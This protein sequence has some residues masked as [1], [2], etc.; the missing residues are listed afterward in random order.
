MK[1]KIFLYPWD[2]MDEG[3]RPLARRLAAL[4]VES[5]SLAVVYH[6]GKLLLP[7]NPRRRVLLHQD[8]RSYF[9]FDA[10]CYGRLRPIPGELLEGRVTSF[11][12][13]TL[14]AFH[15]ENIGVCAWVVVLHS[16]R[17]ARQNP[18]CAQQ[19]AWGEPSAHSLCPSHGEVFRYALSLLEDIARA[20]VDE[21]HLESVE[22]AGFLHGAHHEMQA[23]ANTSELDR[24]MGL[25][26]C[27]ACMERAKQ[28]G[29]DA[30]ALREAVRKRAEQFFGFEP[31]MPLDTELW[32]AYGDLRAR[33][34]TQL[35]TELRTRLRAQGLHTGIK[36]I[37]WMTDGTAP[38]TAGVDPALLA[39]VIDGILAV[40]P[41]APENVESFVARVR[42]AVPQTVPVTGG[43]RLMAPQTVKPQQVPDYIRAYREQ[44][45]NEVIFYNYGMAPFPFLEAMAG[46]ETR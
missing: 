4:G 23:Y 22:Y 42:S 27:P 25:C 1:K 20:G 21:L 2:V 45:V 5:V 17:L 36:P 32:R 31:P 13:D 41:S 24:L 11:W 46:K 14:T 40:Y 15:K 10:N 30:P 34:I 9:P 28:A 7:H 19:N 35:Y 16:D 37:L 29:V 38:S 18:D 39:P 8:S 26:F 43:V 44:G 33:R 6:S 12:E 3:A